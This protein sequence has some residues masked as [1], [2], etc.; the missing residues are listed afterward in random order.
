[1]MAKIQ[2]YHHY[3]LPVGLVGGLALC[4]KL[5]LLCKIEEADKNRIIACISSNLP[6][7]PWYF[8]DTYGPTVPSE[9]E[10]FWLRM[11]DFICNSRLP[12]ILIG[13]LNGT[14]RNH[15]SLN[16]GCQGFFCKC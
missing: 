1:M 9:K 5:G 8:I 3:I 2:Y 7:R 15:E 6:E 10:A 14:L 13:D 12:L 4:W 16:Y 11:G